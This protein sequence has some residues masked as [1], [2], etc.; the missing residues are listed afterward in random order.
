MRRFATV[1]APALAALAAGGCGGGSHATKLADVKPCLSKLALVV[2]NKR[3][4]NQS[5]DADNADLSYGAG[6]AGATAAHLTFYA[7]AKDAK[8]QIALTR[9]ATAAGTIR[10]RSKPQ[11]V[12][13][14]VVLTWSSPPA[15]AQRSKLVACLD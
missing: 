12:G 14:T 11:L 2:P 13:D 4:P 3:F 6:S 7:H 8:A 5:V 10:L 9:Q 1:L 15:P